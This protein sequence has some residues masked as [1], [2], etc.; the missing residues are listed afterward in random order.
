MIGNNEGSLFNEIAGIGCF[1]GLVELVSQYR[2]KKVIEIEEFT[3]YKAKLLIFM[4][5]DLPTYL[6]YLQIFIFQHHQQCSSTACKC[7]QVINHLGVPDSDLYSDKIWY[8]FIVSF[9]ES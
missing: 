8:E 2:L 3:G 9:I 7:Q 6:E 1:M 4:T 5:A